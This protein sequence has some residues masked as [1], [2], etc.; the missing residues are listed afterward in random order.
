MPHI[1]S[2]PPVINVEAYN[3]DR[4]SVACLRLH[5]SLTRTALD[6]VVAAQETMG[7]VLA[8]EI[9]L[10][11]AENKN[12]ENP[13][14]S[15]EV[16]A[17]AVA[18]LSTGASITCRGVI[19]GVER[20]QVFHTHH[21]EFMFQNPT[22]VAIKNIMQTLVAAEDSILAHSDGIMKEIER[23]E[24]VIRQHLR[25]VGEEMENMPCL[26]WAGGCPAPV[27]TAPSPPTATI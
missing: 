3:A 9:A 20:M 1:V 25:K 8:E 13:D 7:Y 16:A 12:T 11:A 2:H 26:N 10:H 27:Q 22:T 19:R 4:Q 6:W 17:K 24:N 15:E 21:H 14:L 18:T 23:K 5:L